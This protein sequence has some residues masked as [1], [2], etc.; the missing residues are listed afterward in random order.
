MLIWIP[1]VDQYI[2]YEYHHEL[3]QVGFE[4]PIHE[5]H[6]RRSG[7]CKPKRHH[8]KFI[9][10]IS[11]A[12]YSLGYVLFLNSEVVFGEGFRTPRLEKKIFYPRQRVVVLDR[13]FV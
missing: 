11:G 6:K 2:I 12:K 9:V 7:I 4:D 1:R 5:I 13:Y 8:Y 10:S 3:I